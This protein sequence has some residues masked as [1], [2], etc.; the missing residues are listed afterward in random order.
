M[1]VRWANRARAD[2]FGIAD[3]YDEIEPAVTD[4]ILDWIEAAP[5]LLGDHPR[6]GEVVGRGLRKWPVRKTP[7]ILLDRVRRDYVEIARV[8]HA[9][10]DWKLRI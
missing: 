5:A 1:E 6:A 7:F 4:L 8:V 3:R 2:L 10:G 9:A